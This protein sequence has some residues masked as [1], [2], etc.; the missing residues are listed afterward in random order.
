MRGGASLIY[1]ITGFNAFTSQQGVAGISVLGLNFDPTGALL[2]GVAGPGNI[3]TGQVQVP[4]SQVNWTIAG[5]VLPG[6]GQIRCDSPLNLVSGGAAAAPNNK[7]CP[8]LSVDPNFGRPSAAQWNLGVQHAFN[9]NMSLQVAYVGTRGIGLFGMN[10]IN[11]PAPGSGWASLAAGATKCVPA[12]VASASTTCENMSRPYFSKFPYLSQIIQISDQD[13]STYNGMQ[14]TLTGR[15]SHGL[16]YLVGYTYAHALSEADGDWN[17]ASLPRNPSD[18]RDSLGNSNTDVRHRVTVSLT[19]A[20]PEKKGFYQLLEGWKLNSIV[21][22]QSALPWSVTDATNQISGIG[23]STD[24]WNFYGNP[25]NFDGLGAGFAGAAA[26]IP[27]FSGTSNSTCLAQATALDSG[28]TPV[29]PGG[30]NQAAL[31]KY[32]CY[33]RNGSMLL[34]PAFG[35][36][37]TTPVGEFRGIGLKLWDMSLEKSIRF[38]ER[39]SG[40][41]RFEVFN[42]LNMTQYAAPSATMSATGN[43]TFGVSTATP[44]V[45]ISNPSVGSGAPRGIQMGLKLAF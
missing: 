24:T 20:L 32:G 11:A 23:D 37:G 29:I 38:T 25:H 33:I 22:V 26:G 27:Y 19:Y 9:N 3:T 10:D 42:I 35:T 41:F 44:D 17:G 1:I 36:I 4:P 30:T 39:I 7:P 45:Q 13:F 43:Q 14:A 18:V 8:L 21:N 34:P 6:N 12:L 5:P 28:F 15:P 2:D 40:T 16:S 31:A